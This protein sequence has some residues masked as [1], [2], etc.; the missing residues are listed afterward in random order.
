VVEGTTVVASRGGSVRRA[1]AH[2]CLGKLLIIEHDAIAGRGHL[3]TLY[4]HLSSIDVT[5]N[6]S[7]E[8]GATVG[9]SGNTGTCTDGPHLHFELVDSPDALSWATA[10]GSATGQAPNYN[11]W[12]DPALNVEGWA[13]WRGP[14][15]RSPKL[16]ASAWTVTGR[17]ALYSWN[18]VLTFASQTPRLGGGFDVT[19]HFMWSGSGGQFGRENFVGT[20]SADLR[21]TLTG[22]ELVPPTSGIG[23]A[24]YEA[25]LA[26]S[27]TSIENG[28]WGG[29]G[30]T[31]GAWSAVQ[32]AGP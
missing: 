3:Y 25:T 29:T 26:P 8:Q 6:S 5:L 32:Q 4:A 7:V 20:L 1:A 12:R 16:T 10:S 27:F 18:S 17:D 31:P 22:N 19:G 13:R 24:T 14:G 28:T 23:L 9:A 21:L 11:A 30:T 2:P 15:P